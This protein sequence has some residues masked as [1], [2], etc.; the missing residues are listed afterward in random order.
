MACRALGLDCSGSVA[1]RIFRDF[2]LLQDSG[3]TQELFR[4]A[5]RRL[6]R[7]AGLRSMLRSTGRGGAYGAG[8]RMDEDED[9]DEDD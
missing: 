1:A 7:D 5:V 4:A 9:E 6:R 2:G 8:G 3:L